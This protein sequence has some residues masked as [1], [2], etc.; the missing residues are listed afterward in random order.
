MWTPW[1]EA[2]AGVA[3]F[4]WPADPA[5]DGAGGRR[6]RWSRGHGG[7][8]VDA[9]GSSAAG[10]QELVDRRAQPVYRQFAVARKR[11]RPA[12][13]VVADVLVSAPSAR[14]VPRPWPAHVPQ[15][16][17]VGGGV[18]GDSEFVVGQADAVEGPLDDVQ[19]GDAVVERLGEQ[20]VDQV[21][22]VRP[23]ARHGGSLAVLVAPVR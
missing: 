15:S 12:H 3:C 11:R 23:G 16:A 7:L 18:D 8:P 5:R 4:G 6:V 21:V 1:C 10:G 20:P 19:G 2:W 13:V 9:G 17:E 22:Y 14:A